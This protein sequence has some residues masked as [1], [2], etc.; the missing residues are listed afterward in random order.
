MRRRQSKRGA[1]T[2]T[3]SGLTARWTVPRRNT[4]PRS[5]WGLAGRRRLALTRKTTIENP[6][7]S[8]YPRSG[9]WGQVIY[10][11][12]YLD[13]LELHL[14]EASKNQADRQSACQ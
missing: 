12:G 8:H 7:T 6:R 4:L 9:F 3:P 11:I 13:G 5:L 14:K 10:A 2:T 1:S